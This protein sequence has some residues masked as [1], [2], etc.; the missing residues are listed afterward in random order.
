MSQQSGSVDPLSEH[1]ASPALLTSHGP[2]RHLC[3]QRIRQNAH[4]HRVHEG[5]CVVVGRGGS[6]RGGRVAWVRAPPRA[7]AGCAPRGLL[8]GVR[9]RSAHSPTPQH[10][11]G[12]RQHSSGVPHKHHHRAHTDCPH[13]VS[14]THV[15]WALLGVLPFATR[16]P[17]PLSGGR[18]IWGCCIKPDLLPNTLRRGP[19]RTGCRPAS[20][21]SEEA[22]L[23]LGSPRPFTVRE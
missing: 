18:W 4:H 5:P 16:S 22:C 13:H 23:A 17:P 19:G 2:H 12:G 7:A 8:S 3:S 20:G 6:A 9:P 11:I 14:P 21:R 1:P 15:A 10:H